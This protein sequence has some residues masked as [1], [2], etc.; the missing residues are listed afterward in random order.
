MAE[1]TIRLVSNP[2]TGKR[3]IYIDYESQDDALPH[4]HEQDHHDVVERL[5]GQ[6]ILDP[7]EIG[8]IK[9]GRVRPEPPQREQITEGAPRQAEEQKG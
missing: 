5:L 6:G 4:E 1:M 7:D 9:V 3:D 2:S 8:Q